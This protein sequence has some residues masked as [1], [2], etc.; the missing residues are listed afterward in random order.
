MRSLASTR[1]RRRDAKGGIAPHWFSYV[2]LEDAD[3]TASRARELGGKVHDEALDVMNSGRMAV[4]EYPTDAVLAFWNRTHIGADQVNDLG[5][6]T[7]NELQSRDP[8][9]AAAFYAGLFGW[10]TE[11]M[12]ENGKLVYVTTKNAS[13]ANGG[14][15]PMTRQHGGAPP[16]YLPYFM[17]PYCDGVVVRVRK[18]GGE[19]LAGPFDVGAVWIAVAQDPPGRGVR[20]LRGREVRIEKP[21]RTAEIGAR[22]TPLVLRSR[23]LSARE[24]AQHTAVGVE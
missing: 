18:L 1:W 21:G 11:Y 19:A 10:E 8:E 6:L 17:V 2:C 7:W 3:A 12:T 20:A 24:H 15:M 22:K 13:F 5:R 9:T 14:I 23:V 16:R 4:I